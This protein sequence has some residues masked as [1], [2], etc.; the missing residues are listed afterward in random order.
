MTPHRSGFCEPCRTY[1][2]KT[3]G[4]QFV[5]HKTG[6]TKCHLCLRNVRDKARTHA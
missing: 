6:K 4:V 5:A 1:K 3:C 2:C